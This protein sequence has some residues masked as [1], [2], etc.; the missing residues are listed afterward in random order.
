MQLVVPIYQSIFLRKTSIFLVI[1]KKNVWHA[2]V[3]NTESPKTQTL[4]IIISQRETNYPN[5]EIEN[6][7]SPKE[8]VTLL[9]YDMK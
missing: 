7:D 5:H 8:I 4:P 1:W 3:V 2:L 6:N 9:K